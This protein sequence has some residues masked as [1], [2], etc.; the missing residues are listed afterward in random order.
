MTKTRSRLNL[1]NSEPKKRSYLPCKALTIGDIS[2]SKIW[3]S[4]E[5]YP[6][7]IGRAF[8]IGRTYGGTKTGLVLCLW[9]II[10]ITHLR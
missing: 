10:L 5:L 2:T 1:E 9:K 6:Y 7:T 4:L 3:L 8:H